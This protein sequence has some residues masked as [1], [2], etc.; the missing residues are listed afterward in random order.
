[1]KQNFDT[2]YRLAFLADLGTR[3]YGLT[4]RLLL[5][6]EY[7]RIGLSLKMRYWTTRACSDS[8]REL[9]KPHVFSGIILKAKT[10][11]DI[12]PFASVL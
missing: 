8:F 4:Y 5:V 7:R 6:S 2:T 9:T 3:L 11:R 1:M 10:Q 12:V